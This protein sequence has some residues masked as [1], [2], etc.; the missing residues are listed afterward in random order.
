MANDAARRAAK[1]RA[2]MASYKKQSPNPIE[3]SVARSEKAMAANNALE[4]L[5]RRAAGHGVLDSSIHGLKHGESATFASPESNG[6]VKVSYY[7]RQ[8]HGDNGQP[9]RGAT[10]GGFVVE[11]PNGKSESFDHGPHANTAAAAKRGANPNAKQWAAGNAQRAVVSHFSRAKLHT[12]KRV[13]VTTPAGD[14]SA[15]PGDDPGSDQNCKDC[16]RKI[17]WTGPNHS[18]WTHV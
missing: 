1:H 11:Y 14:H 12:D 4:G 17:T 5:G 2:D 8:S 16:G 15:R 7:E 18:D 6:H 9:V 3:R 10:T 13:L